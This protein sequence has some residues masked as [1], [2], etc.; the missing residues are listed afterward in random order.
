MIVTILET[1]SYR[2]SIANERLIV[3][4]LWLEWEVDSRCKAFCIDDENVIRWIKWP[5]RF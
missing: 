3:I 5:F 1:C 4:H 2:T